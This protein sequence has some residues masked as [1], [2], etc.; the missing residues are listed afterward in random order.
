MPDNNKYI[1]KYFKFHILC[2][3]DNF[4]LLQIGFTIHILCTREIILSISN[5]IKYK[6]INLTIKSIKKSI[7]LLFIK[8][9]NDAR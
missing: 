5:I 3:L 7:D 8:I 1:V 9:N 4:S 2:F 6:S